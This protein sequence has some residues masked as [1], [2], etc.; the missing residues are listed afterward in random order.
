MNSSQSAVSHFFRGLF[1][2]KKVCKISTAEQ[3][4]NYLHL[5]KNHPLSSEINDNSLF[6]LQQ[7]HYLKPTFTI[8][9]PKKTVRQIL[10]YPNS[11]LI[12]GRHALSDIKITGFRISDFHA[13]A[14][15]SDDKVY[16]E[17]LHS[18]SGT[19]VN[20][21]RLAPGLSQELLDKTTIT[22]KNHQFYF[23]NP[24]LAQTALDKIEEYTQQKVVSDYDCIC[25]HLI[26]EYQSLNTWKS[27]ITELIVT[28][29]INETADTKTIRLAAAKPLL[30]Y[31]Q[32]G[33]FVTLHLNI[34]GQEVKRS[35]SIASSPSRPYC[36]EITVKKTP[37]GLVSNWLHNQL[38]I[39]DRLM[40]KGP[41]G[42]FS[43]FNHPAPKLLLIA[44]GSGVVPIMSML[45]WLTD[46]SAEVD[47]QV[48][49]S[50]RYP[51]DII[52]RRELKLLQKRHKNLRIHITLTGNDI[53]K[54]N[55]LGLRGRVKKSLLKQR[56]PNLSKREVFICGPDAFMVE[57]GKHLQALK[58]PAQQCHKESFSIV[59]PIISALPR[60]ES[61]QLNNR[62]GK[63]RV[64]F[65]KSGVQAVT[66]G[67]E[68][69][70]ML[71]QRYGVKIDNEC[72]SGSCGECMVKCLQGDVAMNDQV[73]ISEK[74]KQAGWVYSCSA[75]PK[76]DLTLDI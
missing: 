23:E 73:E 10:L 27:S 42:R 15:I 11:E 55:W 71:A 22:I 54:K 52:Y 5:Q 60:A 39:G 69:L 68:N 21:Q 31:Y 76:S 43:C 67:D 28:A 49:L 66:N 7:S 2:E 32:P 3:K 64:N 9:S 18:K 20:G 25:S 4:I 57:V 17:D 6:T 40:V 59:S 53:S 58:L 75:F 61:S 56:V 38:Q 37:G 19:F 26:N 30:F 36:I 45:R 47:V 14:K 16:I 51:N 1:A 48:V 34:D 24:K 72:L 63:F 65:T 44:A 12:I 29:I 33:Q 8:I 62:A 35:Y 74:E 46:V 41:M 70:L 13:K 50:F